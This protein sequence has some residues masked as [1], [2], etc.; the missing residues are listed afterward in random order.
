MYT[1]IF[2][3]KEINYLNK[4]KH[5]ILFNIDYGPYDEGYTGN[6]LYLK[7]TYVYINNIEEEYIELLRLYG[8]SELLNSINMFTY[9]NNIV[10]LNLIQ[11]PLEWYIKNNIIYD[12]EKF[13]EK[14]DNESITYIG[15]YI[16]CRLNNL[17]S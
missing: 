5:P 16:Y 1:I 17:I 11:Q 10:K 7:N 8:K 13:T 15:L 14:S 12:D 3:N 2:D 9:E 6:V 4:I